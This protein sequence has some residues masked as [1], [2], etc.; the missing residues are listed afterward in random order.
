M[1][2]KFRMQKVLEHRKTLEDIAKSEFEDAVH[3]LNTEIEKLQKMVDDKKQSRYVTYDY[4]VSDKSSG[5]EKKFIFSQAND[6]L[7]LQDIRIEKQKLAV[8]SAEKEVE[9]KREILKN[10]AIDYK[11]IEKFKEN[12]KEQFKEELKRKE[13]TENDEIVTLR[14]AAGKKK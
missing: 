1:K 3:K 8:Q 11:I 2:F 7:K 9:S 6:F 5:T 12:K 14:F 13:Q 4:Q 10:K